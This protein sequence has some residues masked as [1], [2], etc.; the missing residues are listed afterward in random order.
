MNYR[1]YDVYELP[2]NGQGLAA[3]EML[4]ILKHFDLK[5]MGPG[6]ADALTAMLEAK[7]LAYEDLAKWYADPRFFHAP[8]KGL[9]S[10][11]MPSSG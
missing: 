7:R 9:I 4:Q 8:L 10:D 3:L 6:S 1:G 2:P 5:K 11:V